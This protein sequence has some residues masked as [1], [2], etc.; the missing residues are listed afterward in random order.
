[1]SN[2]K[3]SE[4][5]FKEQELDNKLKDSEKLFIIFDSHGYAKDIIF[6]QEQQRRLSQNVIYYEIDDPGTD[7]RA[8]LKDLNDTDISSEEWKH[9]LLLGF[10]EAALFKLHIVDERLDK[11]V[12]EQEELE[13]I[14]S[15]ELLKA[16]GIEVSGSDFVGS[17]E[18]IEEEELKDL[19]KKKK[20]DVVILHYGIIQKIKEYTIHPDKEK[21]I[22]GLIER[23]RKNSNC[24][25]VYIHSARGAIVPSVKTKSIPMAVVE[26]WVGLSTS[27][28]EIIHELLSLKEK[29][30]VF[31]K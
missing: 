2:K 20:C 31:K 30:E 7:I 6:K 21:Y 14:P 29:K 4:H 18:E 11:K 25:E 19:L 15:R 26:R 17:K 1:V 5:T 8:I 16:K 22:E 13:G 24:R 27:K 9:S 12:N 23:I 28:L 3:I 10:V